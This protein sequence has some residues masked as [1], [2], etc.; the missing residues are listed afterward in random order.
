MPATLRLT[1]SGVNAVGA[2]NNLSNEISPFL[3]H[4]SVRNGDI[5]KRRFQK[6]KKAHVFW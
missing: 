3:T 1:G 6:R 5:E 2:E 4:N